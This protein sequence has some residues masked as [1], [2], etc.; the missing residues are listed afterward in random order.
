MA[1]WGAMVLGV[2]NALGPSG[3]LA[4]PIRPLKQGSLKGEF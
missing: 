2:Q 4:V 3:L 1:G